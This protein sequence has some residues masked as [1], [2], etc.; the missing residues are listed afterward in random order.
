MLIVGC[1]STIL[2]FTSGNSHSEKFAYVLADTTDANT[3]KLWIFSTPFKFTINFFEVKC[4]V[5]NC[6]LQ[7]T[8]ITREEKTNIIWCIGE[9][10]TLLT[11]HI[12][13][14]H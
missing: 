10:V 9:P 4:L 3:H 13:S 7:L 6:T 8:R 14:I 11:P 12:H 5:F 2:L 1:V